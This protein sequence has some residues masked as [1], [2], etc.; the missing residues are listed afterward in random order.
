MALELVMMMEP[1]L[2]RNTTLTPGVSPET[3]GESPL[4]LHPLICFGNGVTPPHGVFMGLTEGKCSQRFGDS[5][6]ALMSFARSGFP[7]VT[8]LAGGN[9]PALGH[10]GHLRGRGQGEAQVGLT[11]QPVH[12]RCFTAVLIF[13]TLPKVEQLF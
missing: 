5:F 13:L 12:L 10:G 3:V 1:D 2:A 8:R 7:R 11:P 9:M 4:L 6:K